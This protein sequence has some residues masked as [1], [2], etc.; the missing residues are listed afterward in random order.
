M[1]KLLISF[2]LLA[3]GCTKNNITFKHHFIAKEWHD[4]AGWDAATFCDSS[5]TDYLGMDTVEL[6]NTAEYNPNKFEYGVGD[7]MF[8]RRVPTDTPGVYDRYFSELE[9]QIN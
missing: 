6:D 7:I 9:V 5:K 2:I 8:H 3:V 1:K 4:K